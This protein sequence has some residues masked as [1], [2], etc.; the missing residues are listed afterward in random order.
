MWIEKVRHASGLTL[1]KFVSSIIAND[2][3]L[4]AGQYNPFWLGKKEITKKL[5][6][7]ERISR[8]GHKKEP[9]ISEFA[10]SKNAEKRIYYWAYYQDHLLELFPFY[11]LNY[12]TLGQG[13][14]TTYWREVIEGFEEKY[15]ALA[16]ATL[17]LYEAG[18]DGT[19]L[20]LYEAANLR[21]Q[22]STLESVYWFSRFPTL[23]EFTR[24]VS[25]GPILTMWNWGFFM[26]MTEG[27]IAD[28][29]LQ[30][31]HI[32]KLN[33]LDVQSV[34]PPEFSNG[35]G[36]SLQEILNAGIRLEVVP[37]EAD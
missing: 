7:T 10:L 33:Y 25:P 31:A 5:D 8:F 23:E 1:E 35:T 12:I 15:R 29:R 26:D 14:P 34:A 21:R 13:D 27:G 6:P 19:V 20:P 17:V 36:A 24:I 28:R 18:L 37:G 30:G 2:N 9:K 22:D 3:A 4:I 11:F 16:I 32:W